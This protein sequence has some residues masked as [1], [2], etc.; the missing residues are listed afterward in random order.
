MKGKAVCPNCEH[1]FIVDISKTDG[2]KLVSCP[3]C[4]HKF[5]IKLKSD[6]DS[7]NYSWEEHGEPRKTILSSIKPR[8]KKPMIAVIILVCVFSIG[9]TTAFFSEIF[10]EST[11]DVAS[12]AGSS[13]TVE[14]NILSSYNNSTINNADVMINN[15]TIEQNKDG[16]YK[17]ENIEPG[18]QKVNISKEGYISQKTEILVLPFITSESTFR[19]KNGTDVVEEKFDSFGCSA[20]LLIFSVFAIFSV[21][22]CLRREYFD[23]AIVSSFLAIFSFGFFFIGSVLSIIAFVIILKSRDEFKNGS[24]GKVF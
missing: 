2:E 10:V 8:T 21:M 7:F 6:E 14:F 20:I 12:M 4:K 17:K 3:K 16:V 5:N 23:I 22:A 11:M 9:I 18:I 1:E 24:K 15:I 19:L 13:G